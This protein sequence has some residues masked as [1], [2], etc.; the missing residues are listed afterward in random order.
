MLAQ[1]P[2]AVGALAFAHGSG[3]PSGGGH[4]V[5][6]LPD[7]DRDQASLVK[8]PVGVAVAT[9]V[10]RDLLGPVPGVMGVPAGAVF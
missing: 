3:D 9:L 4:R 10:A 8:S 1:G 2:P 6:V 5:V 7:S